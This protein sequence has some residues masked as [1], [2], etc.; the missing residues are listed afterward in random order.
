MAIVKDRQIESSSLVQCH[1]HS[2][3]LKIKCRR[4]DVMSKIQC[5][6]SRRAKRKLS[7]LLGSEEFSCKDGVK[8]G[9]PALGPVP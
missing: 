1:C 4:E 5:C 9:D 2:R 6:G 7:G 3:V 8:N